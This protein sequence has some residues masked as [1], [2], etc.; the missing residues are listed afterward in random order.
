ME[1]AR[2]TLAGKAK[3]VEDARPTLAAKAESVEDA[4]LKQEEDARFKQR[5][6]EAKKH[7]AAALKQETVRQFTMTLRQAVDQRDK[8]DPDELTSVSQ[9]MSAPVFVDASSCVRRC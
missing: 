9:A 5:V 7:Q 2:P 6:E 4:R 8:E 1:D 3:S